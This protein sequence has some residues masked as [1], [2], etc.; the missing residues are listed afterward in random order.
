MSTK[1]GLRIGCCVSGHGY[2]HATRMVAVLGALERLLPFDL[3]LITMA[4]PWLFKDHLEVPITLHRQEVDV[5]LVQRD[6]L[7]VDMPATLEALTQLRRQEVATTARIAEL[8]RGCQLVLCDIAPL[9]IAAAGQAG[10]PSILIENFTWDWI[11]QGYVQQWPALEPF[12]SWM[13]ALFARADHRIQTVPVG[14]TV[15]CDLTVAPVARPM[16][17]PKRLRQRLWVRPE[18]RL[19]VLTMGGIGGAPVPIPVL[20]KRPDLVFVLP[21]TSRENEFSGNLRFLGREGGWYHPDLVAAADLVA[22]KLGYSTVAEAY[23]AGTPYAYVPRRDFR[24]SDILEEFVDQHLHTDTIKA[25]DWHSGQGLA[26]LPFLL[27]DHVAPAYPGNGA[28]QVAAWLVARL[29]AADG[30]AQP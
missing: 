13:A 29:S 27:P 25:E 12:I 7:T 1:T 17:E 26:H 2:G 5:G 30:H 28:D 3:T 23:H 9:G 19:I 18:Q 6:A 15:D 11:Y 21:G 4:P 16:R 14:R 22:G 20:I 10:I 24:E 8:L